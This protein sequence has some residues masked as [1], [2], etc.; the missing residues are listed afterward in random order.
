MNKLMLGSTAL[1]A[2]AAIGSAGA[3]DLPVKAPP[4]VA[5]PVFSWTGCYIGAHAGYG[6]GR[7]RNDFG[8]AVASGPTEN[9]GFPAEFGP[10]HHNTNGGV[11]GGQVGCNNQFAN[12]WV[13]GIEGEL[14][15]S[16]M[17]G[18]FT[19]P[20]DGT[21]PGTFSRFESRNRWDGDVALRLGYAWGRSLL[22]GKA[23]VAVGSFRYTE[24]HDDFP[25]IHGCPNGGT[26]SV[27][28]DNTRAGLL[29][30]V[31]WEY[32]WTN[33]W[34]FK[35]EYDYIDYGSTNIPYPSTSPPQLPQPLQSFAVKDTKQIVK[36]GVN[37]KFDWGGPVVARY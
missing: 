3:A 33:N 22:Y 4:M 24:W 25:T 6:W 31:G 15:W 37:Y 12:N 32:A 27:T 26:C 36:V 9:E 2:F 30:G 20:E 16:G 13:V 1:I 14:W 11:V 8:T 34:T 17:K 10:F 7:N 19:A 21:D 28:F 23:G 29:L 5:A 35:V 18:S